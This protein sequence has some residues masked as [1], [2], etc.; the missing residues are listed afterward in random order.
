M[1]GVKELWVCVGCRSSM[2]VVRGDDGLFY[3]PDCHV[4]RVHTSVMVP[5]GSLYVWG[6]ARR[7]LRVVG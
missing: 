1:N 3:C 6:E 4:L 7:W 2:R 5:V